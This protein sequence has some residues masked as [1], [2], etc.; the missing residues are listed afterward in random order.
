MSKSSKRTRRK[1]AVAMMAN[2]GDGD[3]DDGIDDDD[4]D[5][6]SIRRKSRRR[7]ECL[8]SILARAN[9]DHDPPEL[10]HASQ[11]SSHSSTN[12]STVQNND[13]IEFR[14]YTSQ[15]LPKDILRQCLELFEMNMS[16]MYSDS[17]WGLDMHEKEAEMRHASARFLV[18][19]SP[20]SSVPSST[21]TDTL[22]SDCDASS[23]AAV[24]ARNRARNNALP[25]TTIPTAPPPT[26]SPTVAPTISTND[27]SDTCNSNAIVV[28]GFIHYRY[29]GDDDIQ[30]SLPITYL[31]EIQIHQSHQKFGLGSRL[32]SLV[33]D[34]SRRLHMKKVMLTVF[35]ANANAMAFYDRRGYAI[36]KCSPSNF[37]STGEEINDCDYEILSKVL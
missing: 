31:Y 5:P 6:R 35:L 28:L 25:T 7:I 33:E 21:D 26:T 37:T 9:A 15:F 17:H 29:E 18:A 12:S 2:G 8:D 20:S 24:S 14:H 22:A 4:D 3:G 19:F 27:T 34:I 36:D 13:S 23:A 11:L 32:L 1:I 16:D 10:S 30:P